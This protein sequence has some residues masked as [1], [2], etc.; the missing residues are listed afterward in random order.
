MQHWG[1]YLFTDLYEELCQLDEKVKGYDK[2]LDIIFKNSD[3]CKGF[4]D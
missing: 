4:V 3:V 2:K 1:R